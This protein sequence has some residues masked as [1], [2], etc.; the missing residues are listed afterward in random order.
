[1]NLNKPNDKIVPSELRQPGD[2]IFHEP[3]DKLDMDLWEHEITMNGGGNWE[4]QVY[5]NN[6]TNSYV[7]D[8]TLFLQPSLTSEILGEAALSSERLDLWGA[9]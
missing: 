2:L 9:Q 7:K 4:F 8:S 3:F 1:M 5:Y 6:R